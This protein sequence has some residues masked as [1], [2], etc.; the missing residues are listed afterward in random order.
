[1]ETKLPKF[2][3]GDF[4]RVPDKKEHCSKCYTTNWN[5]ELIKIHKST[6]TNPFTRGL[7]DENNEQIA[8]KYREQR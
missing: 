1:M 8:G 4:A 2:Q 3:V 6:P 7:V 5:R